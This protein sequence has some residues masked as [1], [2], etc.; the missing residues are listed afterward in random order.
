MTIAV[1]WHSQSISLS[2]GTALQAATLY[3]PDK[4][5][6]FRENNYIVF[7][8]IQVLPL[9]LRLNEGPNRY[10]YDETFSDVDICP[11]TAKTALYISVK[12]HLSEGVTNFWSPSAVLDLTRPGACAAEIAHSSLAEK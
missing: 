8:T 4:K 3:V 5:G 1:N 11:L 7:P 6:L 9:L 12:Q 10:G 2:K